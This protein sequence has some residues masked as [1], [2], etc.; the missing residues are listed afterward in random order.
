MVAAALFKIQQNLPG[1]PVNFYI[2][3]ISKAEVF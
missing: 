1:A 3:F 2:Q